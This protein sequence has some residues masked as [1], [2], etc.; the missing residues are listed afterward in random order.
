[1]VVPPCCFHND[2]EPIE[3]LFTDDDSLFSKFI[4][5]TIC[6][7]FGIPPRVSISHIASRL[8][9]IYPKLKSQVLP[10]LGVLC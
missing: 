1:M 3:H 7:A 5:T 8:C 9:E 10:G 2:N 6:I 4:W